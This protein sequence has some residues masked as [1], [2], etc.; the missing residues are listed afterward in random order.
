M[1]TMWKEYN[2]IEKVFAVAITIL[3]IVVLSFIAYGV[4]TTGRFP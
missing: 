4:I 2:G 1:K 3:I